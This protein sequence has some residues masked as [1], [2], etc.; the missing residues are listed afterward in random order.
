M[1]PGVCALFIGMAAWAEHAASDRTVRPRQH[2]M[3]IIG[4]QADLLR[5]MS[6]GRAELDLHAART[7]AGEISEYARMTPGLYRAAGPDRRSHA[8]PRVWRDFEEFRS[9]SLRL[10]DLAKEACESIETHED[11][12]LAY[13]AMEAVCRSC[14]ADFTN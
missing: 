6:D 4:E 1:A 13:A 11:L 3:E 12:Q 2:V 10:A 7:A 14:H 9:R 8:S 5:R